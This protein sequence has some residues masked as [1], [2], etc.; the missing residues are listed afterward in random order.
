MNRVCCR[1][2]KPIYFT[3][4]DKAPYVLTVSGGS[5]R[6]FQ[7]HSDRRGWIEIGLQH[8][9]SSDRFLHDGTWKRIRELPPGVT[10]YVKAV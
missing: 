1:E 8:K 6:C 9:A 7:W 10:R 5:Y 3:Y 2:G 4:K